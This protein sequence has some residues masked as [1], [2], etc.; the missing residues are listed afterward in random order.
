MGTYYNMNTEQLQVL[1][2]NETVIPPLASFSLCM[3]VIAQIV[4]C[5]LTFSKKRFGLIV[6][7]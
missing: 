7:I 2:W 1:Q 4:H 5:I 3:C 6:E